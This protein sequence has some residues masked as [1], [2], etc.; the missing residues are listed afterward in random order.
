MIV[1]SAD[2]IVEPMENGPI[3][4]KKSTSNLAD[5]IAQLD[6]FEENGSKKGSNGSNPYKTNGK[7][8]TEGSWE[9]FF[10]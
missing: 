7:P 5:S 8:P 2:S 1:K 9:Y 3:M 10:V 6:V 4:Q